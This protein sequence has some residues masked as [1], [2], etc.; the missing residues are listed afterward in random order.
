MPFL[1]Y[2]RIGLADWS[3][4]TP[5][6][7]EINNFA[8]RTLYLNNNTSIEHV[9]SWY[10]YRSCVIGTLQANAPGSARYFVAHEQTYQIDTFTDEQS[11]A[12]FLKK[13]Q[14]QPAIWT[15]W[16]QR[17][18]TFFDEGL[19][20][21]IMFPHITFPL[22]ITFLF[23]LFKAIKQEKMSFRKPYTLTFS[24]MMGLIFIAWLLECF[25]QSL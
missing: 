24:G 20:N 7:H 4:K 8:E 14:L 23:L 10:F 12:A 25:P 17:D 18:W 21:F 2:G 9:D 13:N 1:S 6:G 15:R 22:G 19:W 5:G 3:C 16:Y 11:W